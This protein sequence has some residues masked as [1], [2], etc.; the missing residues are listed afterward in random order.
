MVISAT[1]CHAVTLTA[2]IDCLVLRVVIAHALLRLGGLGHATGLTTLLL[3]VQ[4]GEVQQG[5]VHL[6][7]WHRALPLIDPF[8][9]VTTIYGLVLVKLAS[10]NRRRVV[11]LFAHLVDAVL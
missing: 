11:V 5:N 6:S 8:P 4:L 9:L 1:T 7:W 3:L 10:F 2:W